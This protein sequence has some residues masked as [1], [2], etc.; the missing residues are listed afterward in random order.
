MRQQDRKCWERLA[1][2]NMGL[3]A[4]ACLLWHLLCQLAS[5]CDQPATLPRHSPQPEAPLPFLAAPWEWGRPQGYLLLEKGRC[6][7]S[8]AGGPE[9]PIGT[10]TIS[11]WLPR[12]KWR[13]AG[14]LQQGQD[15]LT[16]ALAAHFSQLCCCRSLEL[17]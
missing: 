17:P 11:A 10:S 12:R 7:C 16:R 1:K 13:L 5:L 14:R 2:G 3:S 8:K 4:P 9:S 6:C 15:A